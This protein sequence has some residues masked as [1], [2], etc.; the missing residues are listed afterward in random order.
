MR[1]GGRYYGSLLRRRHNIK[2]AIFN[3]SMNMD[4]VSSVR[5]FP[6]NV[7]PHFPDKSGITERS[8][9]STLRLNNR[10]KHPADRSFP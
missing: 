2:I 4:I 5:A 1:G 10:R 9:A 7:P 3:V 6:K 8:G